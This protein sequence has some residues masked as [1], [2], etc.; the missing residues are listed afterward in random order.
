MPTDFNAVNNL[1]LSGVGAA[2]RHA[3]VASYVRDKIT[4]N[5]WSAG[6]R[7]PSETE[8]ME[9]FG[10]SRT[11]VRQAMQTLETEGLIWRASGKGSFVNEPAAAFFKGTPI[12]SGDDLMEIS[13]RN[14]LR[15]IERAEIPADASIAEALHIKVGDLVTLRVGVRSYNGRPFAYQREHAPVAIGR[16]VL[17]LEQVDSFLENFRLTTGIE[18]VE[19]EQSSSAVKADEEIARHLEL[20]VGDPVLQIEWTGI[21][22][23]RTPV[24][25]ARSRYRSDRYRHANRV[26]I[27]DRIKAGHQNSAL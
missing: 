24:L 17:E 5:E 9:L 26:P 6:H 7:L 3:Q 25:F 1:R 20:N 12:A 23:D 22:A 4:A 2:P 19:L 27:I 21:A 10:V 8:L 18:L 11:V 15:T 14:Q 13:R 16:P